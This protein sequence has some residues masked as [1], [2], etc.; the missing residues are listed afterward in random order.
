LQ[1]EKVS[2]ENKLSPETQSKQEREDDEG[3]DS[4]QAPRRSTDGFCIEL[5]IIV[6]SLRNL[7]CVEN[8]KKYYNN[9]AARLNKIRGR[10]THCS[11]DRIYRRTEEA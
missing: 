4:D 1:F 7:C 10:R 6:V 9:F 11:V 8:N 5:A 2:E 3:D